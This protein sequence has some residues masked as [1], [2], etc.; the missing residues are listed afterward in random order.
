MILLYGPG[1]G[2]LARQNKKPPISSAHDEHSQ[3]QTSDHS[4]SQIQS[5]SCLFCSFTPN[6]GMIR[7]EKA[8]QL[9]LAWCRSNTVIF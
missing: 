2:L 9:K 6:K 7:I 8:K 4:Q 3:A 5:S 1:I